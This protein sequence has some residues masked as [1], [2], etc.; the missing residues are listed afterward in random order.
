[1]INENQ[2]VC[3]H[4]NQSR[5]DFYFT[6]TLY[7]STQ[8]NSRK[9]P[10]N[11]MTSTSNFLTGAQQPTSC[12]PPVSVVQFSFEAARKSFRL[13]DATFG[14][15]WWHSVLSAG[16]FMAGGAAVFIADPSQCICNV[17]D[18][19]LF[20]IGSAADL[21]THVQS[22]ASILVAKRVPYC[23]RYSQGSVSVLNGLL[24]VQFL[25][26]KLDDTPESILL[27]FDFDYTQVGVFMSHQVAAPAVSSYQI[28]VAAPGVGYYDAHTAVQLAAGRAES[29]D[30]ADLMLLFTEAAL[31]AWQTGV[32]R[33]QNVTSWMTDGFASYRQTGEELIARAARIDHRL[34]KLHQKGYSRHGTARERRLH[35]CGNFVFGERVYAQ[36]E[37][38][39][40]HHYNHNNRTNDMHLRENAQLSQRDLSTI[41][42][43]SAFDR[44]AYYREALGDYVKRFPLIPKWRHVLPTYTILAMV[45]DALLLARRNAI[46][47][48]RNQRLDVHAFLHRIRTMVET[49]SPELLGLL[50]VNTED[51][52]KS[53]EPRRL[54][55]AMLIV[56]N[57]FRRNVLISSNAVS[58]DGD[59]IRGF[60]SANA[61]QFQLGVMPYSESAE[62][63][64]TV[65]AIPG[66]NTITSRQR[67]DDDDGFN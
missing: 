26:A 54:G 10:T 7:S 4:L 40:C 36:N 57:A 25:R 20:A 53:F 46:I 19:D 50:P 24:N 14:Y 61:P 32:V 42:S 63:Y 66:S 8:S 23:I 9:Q 2:M 28:P 65:W 39:A 38:G 16:F 48:I 29:S 5:L 56:A 22:L 21:A 37:T 41:S 58:R 34:T 67:H 45:D 59:D 44:A 18:I 33:C 62:Y 31:L 47:I 11:Q 55:L 1:M 17:G 52:L 6:P 12:M 35:D 49:D 15:E 27:S 43:V 64:R 13:F 3:V 60:L 51:L 30:T